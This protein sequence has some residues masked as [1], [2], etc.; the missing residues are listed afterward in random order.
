MLNAESRRMRDQLNDLPVKQVN[1]TVIYLHDV[2][3]VHDGGPPQTNLVRVNGAHAVLMTVLKAGKASTLDIISGIKELL[4]RVKAGAAR[5]PAPAHRE[6]PVVVREGSRLR[7]GARGGD[8]RA[9]G[10]TDDPAVPRQLALDRHHPHRD[11]ARDPVL[12]HG[13]LLARRDR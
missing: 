9:A 12:A 10:R 2:A 1:G 6:R 4:P 3:Y 13:A 5:E 8:R 11:S 7:R